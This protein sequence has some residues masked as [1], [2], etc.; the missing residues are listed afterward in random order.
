MSCFVPAEDIDVVEADL[1]R[2]DH[3]RDVVAMTQ[4]YAMDPMG[5]GGPLP[6]DVADRLVRGLKEHPTTVVLLAYQGGRAVGIATCFRGFS[7][8]QARPLLNIHDLAV[9]PGH[10]AR[11]VGARLLA[12]A[13]QKARALGCCRLTL[14]VQENNARA[15]HVYA[16]AGYAQMAYE[17]GAGGSL[18]YAKALPS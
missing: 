14:E 6:Q 4:V 5:N 3:A 17:P 11:G 1:S 18:F 7:T 2:P 10:R 9:A 13:E 8:F 15:R 16:R 12:A